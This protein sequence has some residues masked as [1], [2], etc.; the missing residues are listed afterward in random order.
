MS[1]LDTEITTINYIL[2]KRLRRVKD[3]EKKTDLPEKTKIFIADEYSLANAVQSLIAHVRG[4]FNTSEGK[5]LPQDLDIEEAVIGA[6]LLEGNSYQSV[7]RFLKPEH[8]YL[9]AHQEIYRSIAELAEQCLP[10]DMRTVISQIRKKGRTELVDKGNMPYFIAELSAKVSQSAHIEY[11]SRL[12]IEA[13]V[14]RELLLSCSKLMMDA[15][16]ETTDSFE[17]LEFL[18]SKVNEINTWMK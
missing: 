7:K 6:L 15:Y 1:K 14:K 4:T 3:L 5:L 17:M 9:Q 16:D 8:F 2:K 11:H 12:L 13:A 10:V 18:Q